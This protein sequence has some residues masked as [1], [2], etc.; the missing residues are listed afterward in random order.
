[1]LEGRFGV[2]LAR[3][4][5]ESAHLAGEFVLRSGQSSTEYFDKYLFEADPLLLRA[6]GE[7]LVRLVPPDADALA[8]LEL[9]G[10]P[11]VTILSQ[12]SGLPAL[13]VRKKAKEY[14]TRRLA[15][16]GE[17][18]GRRLVLIEDV[19]STGGAIIDAA[20]EL[21][22][23][24]AELISVLCV[25]DRESGGTENLAAEGL[26]LR[27]AFTMSELAAA[28]AEPPITGD[29]LSLDHVQLAA[30]SGC[31][32][33]ARRFFGGLL[34]L[35]EIEKPP[36]LHGRG[37]VWFALGSQQLHIGVQESFAPARKAHPALRVTPGRLDEIAAR[38]ST[39]GAPVSWD[40]ALPEYRRFY[41]EDPWGNRIELLS[42]R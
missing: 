2:A 38:L 36:L 10:I 9:G 21:R 14:G 3:R 35:S 34:G 30:P 15:E 31:E 1:M 28:S 22:A 40:E 32:D 24:G 23:S 13:F 25:I 26:E 27:A 17:V 12:L 6:V 39:V 29:V 4:I 16:G 19:V 41:T 5:Y 20:R 18:A 7:A 8:G 42:A 37:G 11:L 33:E